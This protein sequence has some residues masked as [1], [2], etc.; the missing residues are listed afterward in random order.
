MTEQLEKAAELLK[1]ILETI[2]FY[3]DKHNGVTYAVNVNFDKEDLLELVHKFDEPIGLMVGESYVH[4]NDNYCKKTG[5]ELAGRRLA[6]NKVK[7]DYCQTVEDKAFI[8]FKDDGLFIKFRVNKNSEKP[9]LIYVEKY[10]NNNPPPSD[11]Y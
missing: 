9:H 8:S 6:V 4:P 2:Q 10:E 11:I 1:P 3:H 7:F 5:R